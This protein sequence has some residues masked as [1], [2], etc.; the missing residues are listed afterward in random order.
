MYTHIHSEIEE[1]ELTLRE[2]KVKP[3]RVRHVIIK[4]LK[5][6]DKVKAY[7]E[8][9]NV[10]KIETNIRTQQNL[11]VLIRNVQSK[12]LRS[13]KRFKKSENKPKNKWDRIKH[14]VLTQIRQTVRKKKQIRDGKI[15]K[16][17]AK[18]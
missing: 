6:S 3:T 15:R 1:A 14:T 17:T 8:T 5:T 9:S 12:S 13:A 4:L 16:Q 18:W 2:K 7:W 10:T 11:T